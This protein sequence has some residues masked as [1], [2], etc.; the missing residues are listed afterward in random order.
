MYG[1]AGTNAFSLK[2][3]APNSTMFWPANSIIFQCMIPLPDF[4]RIGMPAAFSAL[5]LVALRG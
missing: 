2:L 4:L 5:R 3:A 1:D